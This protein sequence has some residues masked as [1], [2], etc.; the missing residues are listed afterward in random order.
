MKMARYILASMLLFALNGQCGSEGYAEWQ[1][2]RDAMKQDKSVA[3]Y[4]TFE[5]VKD[6]K[7]IVKDLSGNGGE[8]KFVAYTD[9]KTKEVFN[10]LEVI[11][12]RW[13]EKKAVRLDR[14]WYEGPGVPIVNKQFT[15]EVWFRRHGPG[16]VATASHKSGTILSVSGYSRGW[17]IV[18]TYEQTEPLRFCIGQAEGCAR[19]D[20]KTPL[21][22]NLWHHLA[23]TWDGINMKVYINGKPADQQV[24]IRN[25]KRQLVG[26]DTFT[27]EYVEADYPFKIGYSAHGVNSVILD[28]DE[29]AIYNRALSEKEIEKLGRGPAGVSEKEVFA[30]ADAFMKAGDYAGARAEYEKLKGLPSFGEEL[31]LFNIAESYRLEKDYRNFH[32]TCDRILSMPELTPYYRIYALFRQAD[33][34]L[35]EKDY[36]KARQLYARITETEGATGYHIFTSRLKGGDTYRAQRRYSDARDTYITLLKEE[37]S[38][39]FPDDGRRLDLRDRLEAIESLRDGEKE[40]SPGEKRLEWVNRPGRGIYVS[41]QGNDKNPGTEKAP[42]ATIGRAQ[43][44]ARK[45]K[46]KGM[47]EGGIVVYLREGSY[48]LTEPLSFGKD[49]SGTENCPVVYRSYPGEEARIIGG[50]QIRNFRLLD[51]P[52]VLARLP[53][54]ARGKV[55]AADLKGAGITDYGQLVNRG[56]G[57]ASPAA[58]ELIYNGESMELARWPNDRW[59]MVAGLVNPEG[60]YKFRNTPY[61]KGKFLY[62]GSRPERWK[63]EDEI[64]LKGYMGVQTPYHLKHLKVT[65]IDT[66]KKII[67]VAKDPRWAKMK[68]PTYRGAR[69]AANHPYFAYNLLSEIDMPGEFYVDRKNGRLYFYPPGEMEGSEIVGTMVESPLMKLE[70]ASHMVFLGITIDGGRSHGIEISGGKNNMVA[71]SVIRNSGQWGIMVKGG[72]NHSV[73][74]CDIHDAGE[75]GISLDFERTSNLIRGRK[76]LIPSGNVIENNHIYRFNRFCGGYNQGVRIDGIGQRVSHN[77]IHDSPLQGIYF[78]ANDHV[79]EFNELH[80]VVHEGRELGAIYIYGE[81][82]YLMS[83][84]TVIRNNFFHHISY[85]SSPNLTHG[86]NAIHIDAMNA[87]LVIEKNIFYRFP[88]GISST[89]PGNYITNN[90]F[91]DA[92]VRGIGQSDRSLIFCKDRDIDAGPNLSIMRRM[93]DQLQRVRYKQPPWSY[94]YPPLLSLMQKEPA[95]WGQIQGSI[96]ERNINTGGSFISFGAGTRNSTHFENNWDG[97]KPLFMDREK[98]DFDIRPGSPVYGLTGCEPLNVDRIGVYEDKLRASWPIN[99]SKEDIG[100]YYKTDWKPVEQLAKTSMAPIKRVSKPLEYKIPLIKKP[101]RIDGKLEKEEWGGLDMEKAMVINQHWDGTPKDG[102]KSYAWLMHDSKNLYVAMK[103]EPDPFREGMSAR[104]ERHIPVTEIAIESQYGPHSQGWWMEDMVTGPIYSIGG[105]YEGKVIVNNLF[106]MAHS[107]VKKLEESIEYKV[108]AVDK[109]NMEW[110]SE[111]K[112][113]LAEIGI[114]AGEIDRLCFNIGAWKKDGWFAWVATGQSIWRVENAG[115]IRLAR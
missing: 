85:H 2:R 22:D 41:P 18:T 91:I 112:I 30:M 6:D 24:R 99:R 98:M 54:E 67:Y 105:N 15:A 92:E 52:A 42:F 38:R 10:D 53:E 61:Q 12:G 89:Y 106:G 43:A 27:G 40:K 115:F 62:D 36:E 48:F 74:G 59:L 107:R 79:I 45:V 96:I 11:E 68:D 37:E 75:G 39:T 90:I 63:E 84:G 66:D 17:R 93:S 5:D 114:K 108:F 21:P 64:W 102:A 82:W 77:V 104:M 58:M 113:P 83:R 111:T 32:K 71:A 73:V 109:K 57:E 14:G 46:S 87:G 47:P 1:K 3:R 8:L 56:F 72:F 26:V 44:E 13:P 49:D 28:I 50:R 23:V 19:A 95:E 94:R 101:V 69:I 78:N 35:E 7:S 16:G 9:R 97:E 65:S 81:P 25:E 60:D 55:W 4:Y 80:D 51:D 20:S 86:L 33:A 110:T 100:R 29:V 34:Y 31:A 88:N 103:H 76:K 70:D